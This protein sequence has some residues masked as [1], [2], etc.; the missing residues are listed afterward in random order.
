MRSNET[1]QS[2]QVLLWILQ[3]VITNN[4]HLATVFDLCFEHSN[5]IMAAHMEGVQHQPYNI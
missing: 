2:Q 3:I 5:V 4:R 1:R